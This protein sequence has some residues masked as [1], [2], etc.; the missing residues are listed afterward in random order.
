MEYNTIDKNSYKIHTLKYNRFKTSDIRVVFRFKTDKERFPI[1]SLL[2]EVMGTCNKNYDTLR[3]LSLKK[4]ELYNIFYSAGV[5]KRGYVSSITFTVNFINPE[6]INENDYLDNIIKFL[7]DMILF[8]NVKNNE[9]IGI[10]F[11]NAKNE[12]YLDIDSIKESAMQQAVDNAFKLLDENSISSLSVTG[13]KEKV[14]AITREAL[15]KEYLYIIQNS[16]V[17][18]FVMG[19][20]DM[21][22]VVSL[23][24]DNYH[25]N[26]INNIDLNY[27]IKNIERKKAINKMD[28]ST[29]KQS[30]LIMLYN[31][32]DITEKERNAAY[33]VFNYILGSGGLSS[34]LYKYLREENGLCYRVSSFIYSYDNIFEVD[35]SL[36]KENIEKAI[37][38]IKKSINEMIKGKFTENDII[39]AKKNIIN[40]IEINSNNQFDINYN[41]ILQKI[42]NGCSFDEKKEYIKNV[43]K[44]DI[45][46]LA[47]KLKLNVVYSLCEGKNGN[48]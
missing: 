24:K 45:I 28:E 31:I 21:N 2:C 38:L 15:Y 34:K 27:Y 16:V 41:F 47:K 23:I 32:N 6:Y 9:F 17:D 19:N 39:D 37:L 43:T 25:N 48:N 13:T 40:T 26:R 5:R 33:P 46:S 36:S 22:K 20:L 14:K 10:N 12:L 44:Q 11:E 3:K 18:I 8:P 1:T 30:N 35:V 29:F 7:F 42:M 4:E